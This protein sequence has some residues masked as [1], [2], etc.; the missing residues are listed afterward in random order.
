MKDT[1]SITRLSN[2]SWFKLI[3]NQKVIH[4]D[5][6]FAGPFES[7]GI[8][9]KHLSDKADYIF[10]SH[11][12]QDHLQKQVFDM[13]AND[14]TQIYASLSCKD[15]L[16]ETAHLIKPN[17]HID[18]DIFSFDTLFA[19][20]TP[21]GRSIR[22][23]H[24]KDVFLGFVFQIGGKKLYF[25]GDTDIIPEMRDLKDIDIAFLPIGGTYVMDLGEAIEATHI[26][27]PKIV[28]P[29]HQSST[30]L[31]D[32]ETQFNSEKTKAIILNI[33]DTYIV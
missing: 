29:M 19:Y 30:D 5:P 24:A 10:I 32:F 21:E 8:D 13:I 11:V 9:P 7:Q 26:I 22:K 15:V 16:P 25:A 1:L 4:I 2:S 27:Q 14:K 12:H 28:I 6:G 31:R 23:F 20:N 33:N 18:L 3:F 17:I